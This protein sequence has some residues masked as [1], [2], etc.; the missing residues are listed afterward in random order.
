MLVVSRH[1]DESI[2]IGNDIV[3]TIVD[4]RGDKVR[5]GIQAPADVA[6]HRQEVYEA[7]MRHNQTLPPAEPEKS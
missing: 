5:L 3:I 1:R 2:M 6:V 7:I 4:I